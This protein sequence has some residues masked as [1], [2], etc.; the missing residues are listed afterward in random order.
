[1]DAHIAKS[2][3]FAKPILNHMQ[4][5]VHKV[6]PDVKEKIKWSMPHLIIKG[7][8]MCGMAAFKQHASF[9][10]WKASLIEKTL[11][12]MGNNQNRSGHGHLGKLNFVKRFTQR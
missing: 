6:C 3:D 9:G 11:Y 1:M 5:L 4:E 8:M 2:A 10:F 7:E 12:W